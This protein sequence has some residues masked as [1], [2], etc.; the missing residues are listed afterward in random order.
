MALLDFI[1]RQNYFAFNDRIYQPYKGVDMGS[2]ISG[3]MAEVFLQPLEKT[4]IKH[5]IDSNILYFCTRYVDDI[6]LIYDSTHT[7][8]DNILKYIATIH[9][10]IQLSPT[11][12]SNDM[13]HFLDLSIT[14]KPTHIEISIYRKPTTTDTT[15]NFLSNH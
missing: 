1:L 4:I 7:T 2:P 14:R 5:L 10:S 11:W 12:E 13:I 9:N 15:I 6:L 3:T 8:P